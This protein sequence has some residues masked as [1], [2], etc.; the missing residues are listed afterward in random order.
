MVKAYVSEFFQQFVAGWFYSEMSVG[1]QAQKRRSTKQADAASF[2][3]V[4][5]CR[6][7]NPFRVSEN[8]DGDRLEAPSIGLL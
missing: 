1:P 2:Q 6:R 4:Q 5:W 7:R 3:N 8:D